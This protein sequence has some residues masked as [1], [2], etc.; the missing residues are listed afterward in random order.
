MKDMK[1]TLQIMHLEP[2]WQIIFFE[3][4]L[5]SQKFSELVKNF[6]CLRNK[7]QE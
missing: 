1:N 5:L 3:I 4:N 2:C 7:N 6:K